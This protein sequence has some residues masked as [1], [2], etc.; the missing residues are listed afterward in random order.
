MLMR[1]IRAERMKLRRSPVW[2]AFLIL[3]VLPAFMGTFNYLQ[4]MEILQKEWY[5]LWTQHTLFTCYFFMPSL[6]G[7]YCSY[8][9]RLEHTNHNWNSVMTAPVPAHLIYLAK[10][11]SASSMVVLTQ[12][13]IG[14][15]FI[16]S[17][18][19]AG[20]N[21]VLPEALPV[22]LICGALGAI[23]I[24]S[25]QL[26]I[27]MVIRSFAVPVGI[28]VIGGI[29]GLAAMAKGLGVWFPYS[30]M[31]LGMRAN[32]PDGLMACSLSQFI[33]NNLLFISIFSMLSVLWLKKRDVFAG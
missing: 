12:A 2:L 21:S 4:N 23:T 19:L 25:L 33:I 8:L 11:I 5:S 28:S 17:G 32:R 9:L 27:S 22:W 3:P 20:L 31:C 13:W 16:I 6:I 26:L 30:L 15:L 18:K 14:I 24:C 10:L 1:A 7:I 29:A